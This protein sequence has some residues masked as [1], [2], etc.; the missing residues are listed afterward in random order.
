MFELSV[1]TDEI[2]EKIAI[3]CHESNRA[4]CEL[5]GD[6]SQKPWAFAEQWQRDSAIKGVKLFIESNGTLG[7]REMH[8]SWMAEKEASGWVYGLIK[9]SVKKTHPCMVPYDQLPKDQKV[10]DQLFI[11]NCV[12]LGKYFLG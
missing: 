11:N 9:D 8:E 1:F 4:W 10:K 6:Y 2:A 7:P 3:M 12:N 5:N